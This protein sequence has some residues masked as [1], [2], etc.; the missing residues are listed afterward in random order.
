[1]TVQVVIRGPSKGSQGREKKLLDLV[2]AGLSLSATVL[3][4][5]QA[6]AARQPRLALARQRLTRHDRTVLQDDRATLKSLGVTE[7]ETIYLKDLG[8]QISWRTVFLVEYAG[9]LIIHPLIWHVSQSVWGTYTPSRMQIVSLTLIL[10]HF[11]KREYETVM[12]HRFSN[13]TMPLFNLFKN[14][15]HYH[16]LSGLLLAG[17]LYGPWFGKAALYGSL[18]DNL[19]WLLACTN[20]WT[21]RVSSFHAGNPV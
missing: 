8:P 1:M 2:E 9:P 21:V 13:S 3:D 17:A 11:L 18:R 12:V 16:I 14:S 15:A 7:D 5:K 10:L 6:I 4:L 19:L 20:V